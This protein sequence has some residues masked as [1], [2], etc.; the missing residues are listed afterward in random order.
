MKLVLFGDIEHWE[1][2]VWLV[3]T[4]RPDIAIA[5]LCALDLEGCRDSDVAFTLREVMNLYRT[6][7]IDG[8]V[9]LQGENPYYF[10]LLKQIG[11]AH[12]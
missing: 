12:V 2:A 8:V 1:R 6:K 3:T 10:N 4:Y 11:R 9:N 7:Q 5:G